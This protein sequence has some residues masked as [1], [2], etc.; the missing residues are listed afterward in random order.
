MFSALITAVA[1][2]DLF[3]PNQLTFSLQNMF[4]L[5]NEELTEKIKLKSIKVSGMMNV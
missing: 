4:D 3:S 2:A 5:D 1:S